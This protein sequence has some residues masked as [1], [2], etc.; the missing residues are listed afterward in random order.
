MGC[1]TGVGGVFGI[2]PP[3]MVP[4]KL[5]MIPVP[6][7]LLA[8]R[9]VLRVICV[10]VASALISFSAAGTALVTVST[11]LALWS[12][13]TKATVRVTLV[14]DLGLTFAT[15]AAIWSAS[16]GALVAAARAISLA[17]SPQRR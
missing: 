1:P 15:A 8:A 2:W 7:E 12:G 17:W 3:R 6:W 5:K 13:T 4:G 16:P 14:A 11:T 10:I 9:C